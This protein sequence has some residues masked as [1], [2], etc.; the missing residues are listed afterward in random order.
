[1][2]YILET[3]SGT[4]YFVDTS[5]PNEFVDR[6]YPEIGWDKSFFFKNTDFLIATTS[7]FIAH[8]DKSLGL[9]KSTPEDQLLRI[10]WSGR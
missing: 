6:L 4:S 10:I 7:A 5:K 9:T 2:K 3:L 1:M 8:Y